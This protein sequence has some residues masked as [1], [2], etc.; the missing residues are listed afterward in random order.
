[1]SDWRWV[2]PEGVISTVDEWELVASLS[3][4]SLAHYTLVWKPGWKEWLPASQ[5]GELKG[6]IPAGKAESPVE[7]ELDESA[8]DPPAPPLDRYN[9]YRARDAAKMLSAKKRASLPPPPPPGTAAALLGRAPGAPPAPPAARRPPLP[10]LV[11][12]GAA[13]S[14]TATLRPPAAVP[15]PPRAVPARI[16][17]PGSEPAEALAPEIRPEIRGAPILRPPG[18]PLPPAPAP[19]TAP[20]I[21]GP[22]AK[23]SSSNVSLVIAGV[24]VLGA[25]LLGALVLG[26]VYRGKLTGPTLAN[27]SATSTSQTGESTTPTLPCSLAHPAKKLADAIYLAIPPY[28]GGNAEKAYVGFAASTNDAVGLEVD[29]ATLATKQ[30]LRQSSAARLT[31]VVPLTGE[32]PVRFQLDTVDDVLGFSRTI[33]AK[34]SF[35]VGASN[36][37]FARQSGGAT[38]V[39]WKGGGGTRLTEP[40]IAKFDG[41]GQVVTFRQGGQTGRIRVG[42]LNEEGKRGSDLG[43]VEVSASHVGTP[44]VAANDRAALVAFAAKATPDSYWRVYLASVD[45]AKSPGPAA[46]FRIPPGGPGAEA[47]S[48]GAAGLAGGRW[49]VQWT[50]GS[51][52][53]RVVRLQTLAHDLIPV[54]DPIDVSPEGANAGQGVVWLQNGSALSLFLVKSGARHELW[55][56]TLKCP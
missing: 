9:A 15:P 18:T 48:P 4:G 13:T 45:P 28:V 44:M 25:L 7:P 40:R 20:Q 32:G 3:S 11:E 56:A 38:Q 51:S 1:M 33:D 36:E 54:G 31:G 8:K 29:L 37:D 27:A 39:L 26:Y 55:G 30:R 17:D 47:I 35:V 42:W 10:T 22:A 19:A 43:A 24:A 49:L 50:E 21:P 23:P 14:A 53:N 52:G 46:G 12:V 41:Y 5:V 34:P 2:D 16:S 6:A